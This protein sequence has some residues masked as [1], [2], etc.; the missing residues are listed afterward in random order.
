MLYASTDT[1]YFPSTVLYLI[2]SHV[3]AHNKSASLEPYTWAVIAHAIN[4]ARSA[5]PDPPEMMP[6]ETLS[7]TKIGDG[8]TFRATMTPYDCA[9][10]E[11]RICV[12]CFATWCGLCDDSAQCP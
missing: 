7:V 9:K 4:K 5:W 1:R 12:K 11:N 10:D 3:P 8:K 6:I 2:T